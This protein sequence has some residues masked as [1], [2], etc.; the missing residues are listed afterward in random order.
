VKIHVAKVKGEYKLI[1]NW[2][3]TNDIHA[4]ILAL[5]FGNV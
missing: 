2:A 4:R 1:I 5:L 3:A